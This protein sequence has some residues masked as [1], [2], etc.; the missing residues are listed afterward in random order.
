MANKIIVKGT[1]FELLNRTNAMQII[2]DFETQTLLNI[3]ALLKNETTRIKFNK[4]AKFL[5]KYI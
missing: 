4:K 3:V 1:G 2:N 5:Q